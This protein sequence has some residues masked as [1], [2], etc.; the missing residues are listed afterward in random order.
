VTNFEVRAV[1]EAEPVVIRL[2]GELDLAG[3][4]Q[5]SDRV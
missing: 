1:D 5:L 2:I 4:D 3:A